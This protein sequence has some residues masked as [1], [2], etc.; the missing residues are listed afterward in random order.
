MKPTA[1]LS[2]WRGF[3]FRAASESAAP[4]KLWHWWT[5]ELAFLLPEALLRWWRRRNNRVLLRVGDGALDVYLQSATG[6]K[7]L[8]HCS[9]DED[10]GAAPG[11]L[12]AA[13]AEAETAERVLL[14]NSAPILCRS[15]VLP[16]AAKEN[17]I[18]VVGFELDRYTPFKAAKLYY[19]ARL[20]ETLADG[21]RIRCE[22]AA[23]PRDYLDALLTRLAVAGI[24]P[25][26][27]D[28]ESGDS[29]QSFHAKGFNLLPEHYRP[30][31][32]GLALRLTQLF[33]VLLCLLLSALG[34]VPVAMDDSF[35]EQ[36]REDLRRATKAAK[37][38]EA[39]REETEQLGK[40]AAFVLDKKLG[41]PP[42]VLVLEDLTTRLPDDGWVNAM[43]IREKRLEM[44]GQAKTAS[45]LIALL[46]DSPYL[47]NTTFLAPVTPDAVSKMERFRIGAEIVNPTEQE[48]SAMEEKA[49]AATDGATPLVEEDVDD[50][51]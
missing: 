43:Q 13:E 3:D 44:Q 10:E 12:I 1:L 19:D 27:V 47:R 32:N 18:P 25:D 16:A 29:P 51:E 23:V 28:L 5:G 15:I 30:R 40:A 45:A 35:V 20:T 49:G 46:E 8:G 22:F 4:A 37:Q 50:Q 24:K 39:L 11:A 31:S 14:L 7:L 9:L 36:L 34:A 2:T 26:R 6:T 33:A 42:L 38:V 17:L 48:R 21:A 41:Q